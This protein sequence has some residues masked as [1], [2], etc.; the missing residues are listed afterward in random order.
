MDRKL[1]LMAGQQTAFDNRTGRRQVIGTIVSPSTRLRN[2]A[3]FLQTFFEL[4]ETQR[5]RYCVLHSYENLPHEV[6][7][8]LDIAVH[9][10]D[11]PRLAVVFRGLVEN[12]Y[13][14]IQCLNYAVGSFYFV[15]SWFEGSA[16][17]TVAVDVAF[18]HR[19]NG[20]ILSAGEDLVHG[21]RKLELVWAPRPAM[22]FQ[23]LL[24]KKTLKGSVPAHQ[25]ERLKEL[26]EELGRF[27]AEAIASH[28][29]GDPMA[30]AV[31]D[32]CIKQR[33]PALL[34]RLRKRLWLT[35]VRRNPLNPI[36]NLAFDTARRVCR[37][38]APTGI[39]M[40]I[41]GPDGVGKSTLVGGVIEQLGPAFR[42]H[43]VFHWRPMLIAPQ[44]ETG[45][46]TTDPHAVSPRGQLGS[47]LRLLGFF[48]DYWLGY[49]VITRRLVARSGLVVFDRYFND[50]LIDS[51]RY[52]YGGPAWLPRLLAPLVPPPDLLLLVLDAD[53]EVILSRKR[54]IDP[55][56]LRRLRAAYQQLSA[57]SGAGLIRTDNGVDR[58]LEEASRTIAD[59]M[60]QRFVRRHPLWLA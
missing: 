43:R 47:A 31:I 15:F 18:E 19:R 33:L 34:P 17:Q 32:A 13:R 50:I 2:Q 22:E 36:R 42:R 16:L 48:A 26:V 41:L 23:Y 20:L 12:G 35:A 38:F 4:L 44:D 28:L 11:R 56:E 6:L 37:W 3:D 39:F 54:E 60:F 52:R 45:I 57:S 58:S 30:S 49:L 27:E 10:D 29:F 46:L 7:S 25:A 14:P 21:R 5:V 9:P 55:S 53:E 51:R 40:V 8:D 1:E 24:E 59:Y